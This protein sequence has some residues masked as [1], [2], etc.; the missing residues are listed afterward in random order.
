MANDSSQHEWAAKWPPPLEKFS[1]SFNNETQLFRFPTVEAWT[2]GRQGF[3]FSDFPAVWDT[4]S[5]IYQVLRSN[6]EL[7]DHDLWREI[8]MTED[9]CMSS[10][11]LYSIPCTD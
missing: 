3:A 5:Y 11:T 6:Q 2:W 4:M 8:L 9:V 1:I 10:S 7:Q